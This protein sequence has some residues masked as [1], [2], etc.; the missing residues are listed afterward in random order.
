MTIVANLFFPTMIVLVLLH[1]QRRLSLAPMLLLYVVLIPAR[2]LIGLA[3]GFLAP[4]IV[5]GLALLMTYATMKRKIPWAFVGVG[6]VAFSILQPVK[7]SFRRQVWTHGGVNRDQDPT[8]KLQ[9]LSS[10]V[11]LG[12]TF[13]DTFGMQSA[14]SMGMERLSQLVLFVKVAEYTPDQI[15][16]WEGRTYYP[17]LFK[18]IPRLL[19]PEKPDETQ[20][21]DF[22]HWYAI[23]DA[24]DYTTAI[25]IPQLVE[26]YGNF[27]PLGLFIGSFLVGMLYRGTHDM[28]IHKD[29][30]IGA[31]TS[32]IYILSLWLNF[33]S[34]LSLVIGGIVGMAVGVTIF[35]LMIKMLSRSTA[36]RRELLVQGPRPVTS[37]S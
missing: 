14:M 18:P 3:S 33:E 22:G 4:A 13:V 6:L 19:Y 24:D 11:Q 35:H 21:N 9:A 1:I 20:S 32:A 37:F 29:M 23:I 36:H 34:N 30:G 16:Y 17:F 26:F 25:N 12:M 15:P 7:A 27:G 10:T 8:D 2:M 5:V 28:L 31:L